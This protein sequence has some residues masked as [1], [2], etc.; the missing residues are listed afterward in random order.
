MLPSTRL[1]A[2]SPEEVF[3][4]AAPSIVVVERVNAAGKRSGFASGVV[5]GPGRVITSCHA[6]TGSASVR[7]RQR[8]ETL[9]TRLEF[10]DLERDLCQLQ[11][12][13][14]TARSVRIVPSRHLKVGQ[15]VYAIGTPKGLE[16]TLSEGLISSLRPRA[17]SFVIQT[18]APMSHGSSG[19][20]LFDT[21][22]RLVGVATFQ[23]ARGQNL[24][25]AV[26]AS[27][28]PEVAERARAGWAKAGL[29]SVAEQPLGAHA[30]TLMD[31]GNYE[32][33]L[34]TV[35]EWLLAEPTDALPRYA[36]GR[37]YAGLKRTDD[38]IMALRSAVKL[39]PDFVRAWLDLGAAYNASAD[40]EN[41]LT[42]YA[43]ALRVD[44]RSAEARR[45]RGLALLALTRYEEAVDELHRAIV[46]DKNDDVAWEALV[47]AHA[48]E[49]RPDLAAAA[50][51]KGLRLNPQS[52][53]LW[54]QFGLV[55]AQRGQAVQAIQAYEEALR[56]SPDYVAAVYDLGVLYSQQGER[57]K[58]REIYQKLRA[59]DSDSADEFS[60]RYL[61]QGDAAGPRIRRRA[62]DDL[63]R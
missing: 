56:L 3:E 25:F 5:T 23:Y 27:W 55:Q 33:A 4:R 53:L 28:V 26:P 58:A 31:I 57:A 22:G 59:L 42:A 17:K 34:Q 52:A 50:C 62:A 39:K 30:L 63:E 36:L 24:N 15:R 12:D 43:T 21:E 13:G 49:G 54:Y 38:A 60:A 37:V 35:R 47:V 18:T 61:E 48:T 46:L 14:L 10:A 11:V 2:A 1:Q 44:E 20:G 40:Q 32:A 6:V 29:T 41:A 51:R 16:L 7:V 9:S 19:G 45:G 8:R